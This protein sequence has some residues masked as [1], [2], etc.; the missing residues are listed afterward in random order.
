MSNKDW[1]SRNKMTAREGVKVAL[2][3][4]GLMAACILAVWI[5]G[6]ILR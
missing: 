6:K 4:L 3:I 5:L 1:R 2:A